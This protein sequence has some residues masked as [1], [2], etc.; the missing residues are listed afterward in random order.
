MIYRVALKS[1]SGD[2]E[3]YFGPRRGEAYMEYV[4]AVQTARL[5]DFLHYTGV[6]LEAVD[7]GDGDQ[8]WVT[9]AVSDR[10]QTRLLWAVEWT[11]WEAEDPE[12][13][14]KH[15]PCDSYEEAR[16]TAEEYCENNPII[17]SI[18]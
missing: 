18:S 5:G 8:E 11:D 15:E 10:N 4:M 6:L 7:E 13:R 2:T 3:A 14:Y 1:L 9:V 16:E 17:Y 12:I